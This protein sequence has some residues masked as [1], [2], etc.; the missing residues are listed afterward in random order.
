VCYRTPSPI[1]VDGAI[2]EA[3]WDAAPWAE[4]FVDIEV[5]KQPTPRFKTRVKMLWDDE[6]LCIAAE[7]EEPHIWATLTEHDS[8]IFHDPDFEVFID[9]DGDG[10][11][12]GE[13]EINALG[14]GWDLL[15]PRPY[16]DG[17]RAVSGWEIAGLRSAV[18]L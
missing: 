5:A 11:E 15:L 14:T 13:F 12:Y 17:G 2:A 16:K 10:H 7:L 1:T 3:A 8:V 9:P 6:A 18:H 4:A